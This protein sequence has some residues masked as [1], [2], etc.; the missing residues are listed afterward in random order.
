M[1]KRREVREG[2]KMWEG[3]GGKWLTGTEGK[4]EEGGKVMDNGRGEGRRGGKVMKQT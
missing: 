3:K 4:G 2:M 1:G